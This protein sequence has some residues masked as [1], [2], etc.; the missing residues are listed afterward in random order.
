VLTPLKLLTT[1][2][3]SPP[4]ALIAVTMSEVRPSWSAGDVVHE[5]VRERRQNS[6]AILGVRRS[7]L[8]ALIWK[9]LVGDP[10]LDV[11]RLA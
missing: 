10:L 5:Q 9:Q 11:V 4:C 8:A 3:A 7:V 2:V 6:A 1:R